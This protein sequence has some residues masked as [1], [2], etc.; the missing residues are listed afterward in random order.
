MLGPTIES[1]HVRLEAPQAVHLP[2]YVRWFADPEVTRYLLYRMP[3]TAQQ[4]TEWLE[5]TARDEHKVVWAIVA[6]DGGHHIGAVGLERIDWR[7]RH[8]E[9]GYLIGE[10]DMW[11]KGYATA[12]VRLATGYAFQELGLHKVWAH[13]VEP[14][15]AS[16]R[17]LERCGYRSC[18]LHRQHF[19]AGG[20]WHDAWIGEILKEEWEAPR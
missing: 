8:A 16:R 4:E 3:F 2:A 1:E 7:S 6:L 13:V 18:G 17:A 5:A 10:R 14:N 9:I 11:G 19:L 20:R 15:Q 12:A